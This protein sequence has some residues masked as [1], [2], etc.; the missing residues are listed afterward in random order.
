MNSNRLDCPNC[1]TAWKCNGPHLEKSEENLY[2]S[3]DGYYMKSFDSEEWTFIPY[4]KDFTTS[5][6]LDIY[7]TLTFLN[8]KRYN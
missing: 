7:T 1:I 4:E 3:N 5:Q 6:L 8:E 2:R